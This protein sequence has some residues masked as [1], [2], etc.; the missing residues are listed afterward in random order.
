MSTTPIPSPKPQ[1]PSPKPGVREG[2]ETLASIFGVDVTS[3]A[4]MS[5]HLP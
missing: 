3:F 1:A 4:V 5:N 2:M